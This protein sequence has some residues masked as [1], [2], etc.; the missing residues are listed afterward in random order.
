MVVWCYPEIGYEC[1]IRAQP[2]FSFKHLEEDRLLT[3]VLRTY[4]HTYVVPTYVLVVRVHLIVYMFTMHI[5]THV[6][7][8]R[9]ETR[10]AID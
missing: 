1:L 7:Y 5:R 6:Y 3:C 8:V 9:A 4:V 2:Q 10:F